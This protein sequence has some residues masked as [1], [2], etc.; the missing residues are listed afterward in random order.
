MTVKRIRLW[1]G[2]LWDTCSH[3]ILS[4]SI[5]NTKFA[6]AKEPLFEESGI[7]AKSWTLS[8]LQG[9]MLKHR[10]F[11]GW[12]EPNPVTETGVVALRSQNTEYVIYKDVPLERKD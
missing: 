1:F 8:L 4:S 10:R 9:G 2:F 12:L 6:V 3:D 11:S 7:S 5:L